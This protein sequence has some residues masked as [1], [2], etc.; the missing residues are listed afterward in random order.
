MGLPVKRRH[1]IISKSPWI[2]G[3][4][5]AAGQQRAASARWFTT[6]MPDRSE[7]PR[8]TG[9]TK[10]RHRDAQKIPAEGWRIHPYSDR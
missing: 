5:H 3:R 2:G 10:S 7:K 9:P 6:G 4:G 8:P 1:S